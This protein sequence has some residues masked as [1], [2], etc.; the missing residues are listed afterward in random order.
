MDRVLI[1]SKRL[2]KMWS[3]KHAG[4]EALD[5]LDD[6]IARLRKLPGLSEKKRGVFYLQSKALLHFHEDAAGLFVDLRQDDEF[7]RYRAQTLKERAR[8]LAMAR[9][10]LAN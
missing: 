2:S 7:V 1:C 4:D 10:E 3:V 9:R 5:Q 8:L 6:L